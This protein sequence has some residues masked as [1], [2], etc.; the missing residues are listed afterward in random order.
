MTRDTDLIRRGDAIAAIPNGWLGQPHCSNMDYGPN[1]SVQAIASIRALPAQEPPSPGVTAGATGAENRP[2]FEFHRY[3]NGQLMAEGVRIEKQATLEGA[4]V[5]AA[6]IASRGPNGEAP[7]LVLATPAPVVP[8]EGLDERAEY[9]TPISESDWRAAQKAAILSGC[10][11]APGNVRSIA[12]VIAWE[13][14]GAIAALRSA[15]PVGAR[16]TG[17]QQ[18]ETAP[19]EELVVLGWQEDGAWKQEIALASAGERFPNGY[20]N[21]WTHGRATHWMP[22]PEPPAALLPA[23]EGEK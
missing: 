11:M 12:H 7:V 16:V 20:S 6:K 21:M 23:G 19:H 9:E 15:P 4:M 18:I 14:R 17:W 13:K 3:I 5:A 2:P 8:A 22:L 1:V 10:D